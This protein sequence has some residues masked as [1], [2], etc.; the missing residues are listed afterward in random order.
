MSRTPRSSA[1]S[2]KLF[3]FEL[4]LE[5][6]G[7]QAHV[8]HVAE[9]VAQSLRV[10]TQH[11][12]GR[13]A[14]APDQNVLAID[15]KQAPVGCEHLGLDLANA[16]LRVRMVGNL[17]VQI[18]FQAEAVAFRLAHLRRPP[19]PGMVDIELWKLLRA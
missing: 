19:Q 2:K 12:V 10:L 8:L 14:A 9:L 6:D 13:P 15:G 17:S 16:K 5:A 1:R 7:V 11:H 3:G 4:A 18:E